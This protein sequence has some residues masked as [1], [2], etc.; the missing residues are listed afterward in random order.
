[1][2]EDTLALELLEAEG[3][4]SDRSRAEEGAEIGEGYT[5]LRPAFVG[6]VLWRKGRPGEGDG[7]RR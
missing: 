6:S 4:G 2:E 1:M 5:Q 3:L 7:R